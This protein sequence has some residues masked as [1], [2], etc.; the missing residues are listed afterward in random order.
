MTDI[1]KENEVEVICC[2]EI[3]GD[4]EG[5]YLW[6]AQHD[7]WYIEEK[8]GDSGW[9]SIVAWMGT[10]KEVPTFDTLVGLLKYVDE[11]GLVI[12]RDSACL[13]Y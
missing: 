2:T 1:L 6:G 5:W 4:L 13:T 11:Y 8:R 10:E 3:D 12:A 7:T 9:D